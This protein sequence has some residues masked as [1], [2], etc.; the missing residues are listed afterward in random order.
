MNQKTV[1][2]ILQLTEKCL[3][4]FWQQD[5]E[6]MLRFCKADVVWIGSFQEEFSRGF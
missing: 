2:Q 6:Y 3:E 5:Y 4:R 1:H